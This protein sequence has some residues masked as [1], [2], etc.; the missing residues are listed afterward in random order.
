MKNAKNIYGLLGQASESEYDDFLC[1]GKRCRDRKK[2]RH[3]ARMAKRNAKTDARKADTERVRAET[4]I[5]QHAAS[6]TNMGN[7][8]NAAPPTNVITMPLTRQQVTPPNTLVTPE[9]G[10]NQSQNQDESTEEGLTDDM[11][12]GV[13]GL[14]GLLLLGAYL[15]RVSQ[16]NQLVREAKKV[17]LAA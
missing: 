9:I 8:V 15:M 5:L 3:E 1:L 6:S 16:K 7:T 4:Q 17:A 12:I 11:L 13:V 14:V 10:E 2:V